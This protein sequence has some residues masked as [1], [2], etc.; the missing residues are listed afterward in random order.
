VS[1]VL[2][3]EEPDPRAMQAAFTLLFAVD[4]ALRSADG[5]RVGPHSWPTAGAAVAAVACLAALVVPWRRVP[6][7]TVAVLP[8]LDIAAV[9]LSRLD[10]ASTGPGI[11]T[12]VPALWLGH[13]FGRRGAGVVMLAT[14]L[15]LVVPA[16]LYFEPSGSLVSR[17][18]LIV[19][20][21]GWAA[22]AIASALDR[23]RAGWDEA[24]RQR[25]V[26][27]AILDTV[28]VGLV[29]LDA[30]GRYR[31]MNRHHR[32]L[33]PIAFP[34]G[35]AGR[36]GQLGQVYAED[37]TT[38][39]GREDM[40]TVRACR[41][42]EFDDCRIW[43]GGDPLTR[44]ALSVSARSVLD[45]QGRAAGAA[46]AYKD[47]TDL[48]RAMRVKDEFVA[49][50]SH[51]LRTPL[52][53]IHGYVSL[54]LEREDLPQEALAQLGIVDRNTDRLRR[55]VADLL[56]TAEADEGAMN[57]VRTLSDLGVI[58]RE[59]VRAATPAAEAA[60]IGLDLEAPEQLPAL[61][62]PQRMAQVVDN[63]VSN[64]LKYTP[65]GGRVRVGLGVD[66]SRVE[67]VVT[68]TGIGIE[69]SDRPRLFTRFFRSRHA[70]EQSIQGVGLG[71]SIT[72]S[73]VESHGG[74]IEVQSE[75][76]QGSTFRVR[77]PL[78]SEEPALP[79]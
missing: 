50:V 12:I 13:Q 68:D 64:A 29:L 45:E 61:V 59:S 25:R 44:R 7:W 14:L 66:G 72:R 10:P 78:E 35:H 5:V 8:V 16:L 15:L 51:E 48:M 63:L 75:V 18:L 37:G 67:L 3:A 6:A 38:L 55:L 23:V 60:G 54:L 56:H 36:A 24:E 11:L 32:A 28:D 58:V 70:E 79:G 49:S 39:L 9:G 43:I 22:L 30:E 65:A 26:A 57:V 74:R 27:E 17:S 76:G 20:V 71:L 77:I 40:P 1:R 41:G 52:T 73:I 21:V 62:D 19:V 2:F 47:V 46:L 31:S 34:G 53:S 42:E 33:M 69:A 4:L